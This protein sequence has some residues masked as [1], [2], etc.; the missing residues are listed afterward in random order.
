MNF[1]LK[2]GAVCVDRNL[3]VLFANRD[4]FYHHVDSTI[5]S[6]DNSKQTSIIDV[7]A[8]QSLLV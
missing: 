2:N 1:E 6:V 5:K 8:F 3:Q 7:Q 4:Y